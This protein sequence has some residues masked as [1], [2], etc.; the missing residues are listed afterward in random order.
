VSLSLTVLIIGVLWVAQ[1]LRFMDLIVNNSVSLSAYFSLVIFLFPD[2]FVIISPIAFAIAI[3]FCFNRLVI[4]HELVALRA[5]GLSNLRLSAPVLTLAFGLFAFLM[6]LTVY[7]VPLSFQ[8]FRQQEHLL[9]SAFSGALLKT[10]SFNTTRGLTV[11]VR[12]HNDADDLKGLLIYQPAKDMQSSFTTIADEGRF[13]NNGDRMCIVL[14]NGQR[15]EFDSKTHSY[16]VFS[17]DEFMYDLTDALSTNEKR[18]EKAYE[19]SLKE[20]FFPDNTMQDIIK[21]RYRAEAHQRLLLP[22]LCLLDAM[23]ITGVLLSGD[24]GKRFNRQRLMIASVGV[25]IFHLV[26][27]GLLQ[28][29][30]RLDV[31]IPLAYAFVFL[32]IMG[33]L[34]YLISDYIKV[35]FT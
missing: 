6:T 30:T 9:R 23:F 3:L 35:R 21:K 1:S 16:S 33:S 27:F 28:S 17:F 4:T 8:K 11:Y 22:F 14:K 20:L 10:G 13:I 26:T 19:K 12:D 24:L 25:F 34:F 18:S 31:F 5:L 7:I 2:L 29:A 32:S 15:Q